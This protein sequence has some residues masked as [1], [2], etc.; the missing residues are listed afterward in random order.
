MRDSFVVAIISVQNRLPTDYAIAFGAL[1]MFSLEEQLF[2][3]TAQLA[4]QLAIHLLQPVK[5]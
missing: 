2:S 1:W 3:F 4:A 5:A